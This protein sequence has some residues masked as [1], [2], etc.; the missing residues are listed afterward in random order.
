MPE[1]NKLKTLKKLV[2]YKVPSDAIYYKA[3]YL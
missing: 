3:F 2:F 1:N